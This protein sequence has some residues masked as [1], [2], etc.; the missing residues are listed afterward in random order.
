MG[1]C[2]LSC[3]IPRARPSQDRSRR[4]SGISPDSGRSVPEGR[5]QPSTPVV[6][7]LNSWRL[8]IAPGLLAMPIKCKHSEC[9][10]QF[11][12][13]PVR[14]CEFCGRC[15]AALA[16]GG[17]IG[18][19][20][21]VHK[22]QRRVRLAAEGFGRCAQRGVNTGRPRPISAVRTG[23]G[24]P[25]LKEKIPMPRPHTAAPG[26]HKPG[27]KPA[28]AAKSG[29]TAGMPEGFHT[30]T[31]SLTV[32]DAEAAIALYEKA[33]GAQVL[34]KMTMPGSKK[35]MH[36]ALQIGDSKLFVQDEMPNMPGPKQRHASF[37]LY[38]PD[39]DAAY[40]RALGAG[41]KSFSP[42]PICSGATVPAHWPI[43]PAI[44]ERLPR[45]CATQARPRCPRP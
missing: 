43:H 30:I 11:L 31:P 5:S 24:N 8:D 25:H 40:K 21:C 9:G 39:V 14:M 17:N 35:V 4:C 19:A 7:T 12:Q 20:I 36:A 23:L 13:M 32:A 10:S 45:T 37:Y 6:D 26:A 22:L 2:R 41:M 29:R 18:G 42:R 3:A 38:V 1:K 28:P 33:L 15:A 44:T 16:A 34:H 27:A